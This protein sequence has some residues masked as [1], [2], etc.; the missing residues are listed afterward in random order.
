MSSLIGEAAE[1]DDMFWNN[2]VWAEDEGDQSFGSEDEEIKPDEFDSDFNDSEDD[3]EEE[4]SDNSEPK[5]NDDKKVIRL[6]SFL[7][8]SVYYS[9]F[10]ISVHQ[11]VQGTRK[12]KTAC[13]TKVVKR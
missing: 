2:D 6:F 12:E 10:L 1:A 3:N 9:L 5:R 4:D 13:E 11:Q 8:I 7:L